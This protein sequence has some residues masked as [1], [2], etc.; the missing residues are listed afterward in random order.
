MKKQKYVEFEFIQFKD[1]KN[2]MDEYL[3]IFELELESNINNTDKICGIVFKHQTIFDRQL[4]DVMDSK[5]IQFFSKHT[6]IRCDIITTIDFFNYPKSDKYFRLTTDKMDKDD[7]Y[8]VPIE[9][10]EKIN[11]LTV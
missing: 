2:R 5:F 9:Y 4:Y 3:L 7:F 8:I 10:F 6:K 1:V 11:N